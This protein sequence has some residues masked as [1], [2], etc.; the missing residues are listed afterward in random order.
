[1]HAWGDRDLAAVVDWTAKGVGRGRVALVGHSVGGQLVGLLPHP[2]RLSR[3]VTVG[4]QLGDYRLWP[5]PARLAMAALWYG[6]VPGVTHAVGYLPGALGIGHDLPP[7]VALEWARWCRT[8]NGIL[9]EDAEHRREGFARVEADVLAFSFGDDTYAPHA[10]VDALHAFYAN[11][12]VMRRRVSRREQ[13]R[14]GHFGFFR[15]RFRDTFW[16]EAA[17][18]LAN[19]SSRH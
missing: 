3:V 13:R 17:A 16:N 5:M 4:A 8:P 12:R 18:F 7:G 10:A 14:V 6:V 19:G 1:M 11:A 15:P 9:S 2:E